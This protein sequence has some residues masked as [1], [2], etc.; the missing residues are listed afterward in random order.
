MFSGKFT[1]RNNLLGEY[2]SGQA[3][4]HPVS[5][6]I[7]IHYFWTGVPRSAP[8]K[9]GAGVSGVDSDSSWVSSKGWTGLPDNNRSC[10]IAHARTLPEAFVC[11]A[12]LTSKVLTDVRVRF[13]FEPAALRTFFRATFCRSTISACADSNSAR[14]IVVRFPYYSGIFPIAPESVP[15]A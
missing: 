4:L 14:I 10:W 3:L 13:R 7:G 8:L 11:S 5:T 9:V 6:D 2:R 12:K 1:L 15:P